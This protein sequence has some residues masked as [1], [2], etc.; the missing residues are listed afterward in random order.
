M[1]TTGSST[2]PASAATTSSCCDEAVAGVEPGLV[3]RQPYMERYIDSAL[4]QVLRT[5]TVLFLSNTVEIATS[6]ST[7]LCTCTIPSSLLVLIVSYQISYNDVGNAL[8]QQLAMYPPFDRNETK[9]SFSSALINHNFD[10]TTNDANT[11]PSP[12]PS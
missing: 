5:P 4:R 6:P 3:T 7:S 9:Y 12:S 8:E 11:T 1:L 2:P 10:T